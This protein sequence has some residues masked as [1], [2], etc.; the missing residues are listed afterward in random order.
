MGPA[1]IVR[2]A[3]G[4]AT[5]G[6][7]AVA[8]WAQSIYEQAASYIQRGQAPSAIELLRPHLAQSPR[9][10]KALTLLGMALS[11]T[12]RHKEAREYFQKALAADPKF[13]PALRFLAVEEVTLGQLAQA[14][15]HLEQVFRMAPSDPI[16]RLT[17]AQVEFAGKNYA[18]AIDNYARSGEL[19]LRDPPN[20]LRFAQAYAE[21]KQ[22]GKAADLLQRMPASADGATHFGAGVLLAALQEYPN[23]IREFELAKDRYNN[24][25]DAGFNLMLAYLK[26]G[27]AADAVR[28][29]EELVNRGHRK[30]ELYDILGQAYERSGR[31]K[32]AYEALRTAAGIDPTYAASYLDLIAL[33]IAHRNYDLGLE[34]ADIGVRRL[35][36]SDRLHLQRGIVLAMKEQFSEARGEFETAVRLAPSKGLPSVSLALILL[37]MDQPADAVKILRRRV[38]AGSA[39]YLVLWFLGEGLNRSGAAVDSPEAKEALDA[40]SRSVALQPDVPQSRILLA[41]LLA[42][43]GEL[44]LAMKHLS[45]ALELDPDNVTATYQLAQ[46]LQR[47]G[48]RARAKELFAKVSKAKA[49]EREQFTRGG[50]QHIIRVGSR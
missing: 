16:S 27:R 35:P 10:A 33:C 34:I 4:V 21:L 5:L 42:T 40:V 1:Y 48:D 12:D 50:L 31:T 26:A 11:V 43:R 30:A 7:G 49:E 46:V 3:V 6:L 45:R 14:K 37:Q 39:D 36:D 24:P 17:M 44:D 13:L 38:E 20:L 47:K 22:T 18:A 9:D 15:S 32:E 25:Y 23:A 29:G 41:K 19:Y 8:I 28:T 2:R